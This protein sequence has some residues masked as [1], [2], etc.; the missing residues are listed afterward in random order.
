MT[1]YVHLIGAEDVAAAGHNMRSA[2]D[3]FA[4]NVGWLLEA[5]TIHQQK[6]E[7][8]VG[9]FEA[10]SKPAEADLC[11]SIGSGDHEGELCPRCN[12]LGLEP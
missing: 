1:E 5:L 10:A 4:Q 9:R 12:G 11:A 6:M 2:A 7:E 3:T 8:L